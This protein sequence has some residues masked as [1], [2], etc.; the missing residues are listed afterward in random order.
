M[1]L[2]IV[3][4]DILVIS[5][6]SEDVPISV[7]TMGSAIRMESVNVMWVGVIMIVVSKYVPTNVVVM[8]SA[9]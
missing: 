6:I 8:G 2:V 7:H 5:V 9:M 3:I 4:M 1:V